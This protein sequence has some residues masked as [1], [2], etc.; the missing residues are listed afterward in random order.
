M[1]RVV[2]RR[3][4]DSVLDEIARMFDRG[5][6]KEGDKL[7]NQNELAAQLGV[8]RASLRE[9]LHTLALMGVLEQRPGFGTVVRG[10]M[11]ANFS[12]FLNLP[13]ISDAKETI[14]LVEAR[15]FIEIS[16]VE[17]AVKNITAEDLAEMGRIVESMQTAVAEDR[18]ADYVRKDADFH[19]LLAKATG[20]RFMVHLFLTIRRIMEQFITESF[21]A[22]PRMLGRS[23]SDHQR[24]HA[25]LLR[26]DEARAV[27]EMKRHMENIRKAMENLYTQGPPEQTPPDGPVAAANLKPRTTPK[28]QE[29]WH[30]AD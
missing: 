30:H 22:L 14:E 20:N 11:P 23:L 3:L 10:R 25:A 26:K 1:N 8:S 28:T 2:K 16:N 5:E 7:P 12:D 24:I 9:S 18:L 13:L 6:L 17:L 15:R 19:H 21:S 4:S 29:D 27:T